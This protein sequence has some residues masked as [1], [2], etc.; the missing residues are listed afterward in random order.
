M[1]RIFVYSAVAALAV[2]NGISSPKTFMVFALQGIWYPGFLPAP[3]LWM[4]ALSAIVMTLLHIVVTGVPVA[5]FEKLRPDQ[6]GSVTAALL[7][8]AV[9]VIPTAYTLRHMLSV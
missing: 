2:L 9:M 1:I 8:L 6:R 5:L 7:W 4:I 3:L